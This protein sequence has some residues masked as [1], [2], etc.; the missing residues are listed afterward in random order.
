M[1]DTTIQIRVDS[2]L[3]KHA[4]TVLLAMGL[5]TSEAVRM[6]L[7]QTVND[8]AIPFQPHIKKS[9]NKTTLKA[10]KELKEGEYVDSNLKNFKKSL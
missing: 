9:P 1:S 2:K 10:F 3:K 4:E 6:F 8:N 7:Q 5:K